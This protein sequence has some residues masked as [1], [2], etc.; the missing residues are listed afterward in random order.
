MIELNVL[1]QRYPCRT[2]DYLWYREIRQTVI[3]I[4]EEHRTLADIK[5]LSEEENV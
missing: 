5:R 4:L 1:N 2:K 3:M